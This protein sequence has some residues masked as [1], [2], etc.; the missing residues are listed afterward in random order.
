MKTASKIYFA[1][2][3]AGAFA[4]NVFFGAFLIALYVYQQK[5]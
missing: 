1:T 2:I 4:L 5:N 3:I